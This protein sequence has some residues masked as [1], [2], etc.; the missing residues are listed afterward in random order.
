M[1]NNAEAVR[2]DVNVEDAIEA[3][4]KSEITAELKEDLQAKLEAELEADAEKQKELLRK[5][6]IIAEANFAECVRVVNGL[7]TGDISH[8]TVMAMGK[9]QPVV[10]IL[11]IVKDLGIPQPESVVVGLIF[12]MS[13]LL[14]RHLLPTLANEE[15][16]KK[17]LEANRRF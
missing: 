14:A 12:D 10:Q 2:S 7:M 11:D 15:E 16:I 6:T 8:E 13:F 4:I 9:D 1:T 3:E 17:V 5:A